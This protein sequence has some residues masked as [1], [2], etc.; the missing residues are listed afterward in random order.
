MKYKTYK[1]VYSESDLSEMV[2]TKQHEDSE[3]PKCPKCGEKTY[4]RSHSSGYIPSPLG[5]KTNEDGTRP[6]EELQSPYSATYEGYDWDCPQ[7]MIIFGE[8]VDQSV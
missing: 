1:H 6:L 7:C 3:T 4:V 8:N 2:L 5:I